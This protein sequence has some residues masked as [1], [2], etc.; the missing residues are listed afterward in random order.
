MCTELRASLIEA[1]EFAKA[2][3]NV[4][5]A[6]IFV[7]TRLNCI[8][9][10]FG[11]TIA[12]CLFTTAIRVLNC[13]FLL[14]GNCLFTVTGMTVTSVTKTVTKTEASMA[15]T[16]AESMTSMAETVAETV[17]SMSDSVSESVTSVVSCTVSGMRATIASGLLTTTVGVR[18]SLLLVSSMT[19]MV[20]MTVAVTV[21]MMAD[22]GH[23]NFV[24]LPP[25]GGGDTCEGCNET[26][27]DHFT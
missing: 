26:G 18:V 7:T 17:T 6:E 14:G 2:R 3:A 9:D 4:S 15:K 24:L 10:F 13:V 12:G 5:M 22:C 8:V 16:V 1:A 25:F 19:S 11:T 27:A 23:V 20:S 21:T